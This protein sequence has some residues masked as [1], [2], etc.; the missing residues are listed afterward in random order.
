MITDEFLGM[1]APSSLYSANN[2]KNDKNIKS[3][4]HEYAL[5]YITLTLQGKG[6][7]AHVLNTKRYMRNGAFTTQLK[8][9]Q[10]FHWYNIYKCTNNSHNLFGKQN[11]TFEYND[12]AGGCQD[13]A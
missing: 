9:S 2:G 8:F 3:T 10:R 6:T 4:W 5:V 7:Q 13:L 1:R 11:S 12:N